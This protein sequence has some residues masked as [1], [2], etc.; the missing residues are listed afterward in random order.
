MAQRTPAP[1]RAWSTLRRVL[2]ASLDPMP[3]HARAEAAVG[4]RLAPYSP[5]DSQGAESRVRPPTFVGFGLTRIDGPFTHRVGRLPYNER[6]LTPAMG[7]IARVVAAIRGECR[8][9]WL[10]LWT[11]GASSGIIG[12]VGHKAVG[13]ASLCFP[14]DGQLAPESSCKR[15]YLDFAARDASSMVPVVSRTTSVFDCGRLWRGDKDGPERSAD[16]H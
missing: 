7:V 14:A 15:G 1:S 9:M 12:L 5:D 6:R 13:L 11:T 10:W 16:T 2:P 8:S 3:P 4:R